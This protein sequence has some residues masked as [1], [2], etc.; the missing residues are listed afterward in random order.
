MNKI[1]YLEP[2]KG[3]ILTLKF[4]QTYL[5][6]L[7]LLNEQERSTIMDALTIMGNP[8]VSYTGNPPSG[9]IT[10]LS[11]EETIE[12]AGRPDRDGGMGK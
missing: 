3:T 2:S 6:K 11:A 10:E 1:E 12:R 5:D 8:I 4:L 9:L 7:E